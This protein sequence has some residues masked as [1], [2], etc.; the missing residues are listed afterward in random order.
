MKAAGYVRVSSSGQAEEDKLSLENQ[1]K[2]IRKYCASEGFEL[3]DEHRYKDVMTGARSDRPQLQALLAA[4]RRREFKHVIVNDLTR[5]GRSAQDLLAHTTILKKHGIQFHSIKNKV[6]TSTPEGKFFFT[7]LAAMAEFELEL[8]K[9]RMSEVKLAKLRQKKI[10]LG[11]VG[12]GYRWDDQTQKIEIEEKEKD[13]YLRLVREYLDLEKSLDDVALTMRKEGIPT[14]FGHHWTSG[15]IRNTFINSIHKGFTTIKLTEE[16]SDENGNKTRKVVEEVPFTC[17]PII[18]PDRWDELQARLK[19]GRRERGGRPTTGADRFVLRDLLECGI[20]GA[21]LV[22]KY[23]NSGKNKETPHLYYACFNRVLSQKRLATYGREERCPLPHIP[24]HNLDSHI[25]SQILYYLA[26]DINEVED[27]G[28][29]HSKYYS[30]LVNDQVFE[31][32]A[33]E[34]ERNPAIQ[35]EQLARKERGLKRLRQSKDEPNFVDFANYNKE[36]AEYLEGIEKIKHRV[37]ELTRLL[38][39]NERMCAQQEELRKF[40]KSKQMMEIHK[41]LLD[42]S[43]EEMHRLLKGLLDGKGYYHSSKSGLSDKQ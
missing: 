21:K 2:V 30:A 19:R 36:V 7:V 38:K 12:Y 29:T 43:N 23:Y 26:N 39:E 4:A 27:N 42:L 17:E 35:K 33:A 22:P 8:I 6:D 14:R 15:A 5:F 13:I 18:S 20:C 3:L 28:E 9:V 11:L 41:K 16:V 34:Y 25:S 1:E 31:D 10:I 40:L 32:K 37:A 24:A